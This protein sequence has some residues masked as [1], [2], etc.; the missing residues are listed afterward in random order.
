[1]SGVT[2]SMVNA[3]KITHIKFAAASSGVCNNN[4]SAPAVGDDI[5][6][7]AKSP[8]FSRSAS[9]MRTMNSFPD[10]SVCYAMKIELCKK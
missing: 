5:S 7:I 3:K 10:A 1:M 2:K 4:T 8:S 9:S 6:S